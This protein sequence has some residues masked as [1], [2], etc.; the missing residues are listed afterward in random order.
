MSDLL[1]ISILDIFKSYIFRLLSYLGQEAHVK[2]HKHFFFSLTS[3]SKQ[4][5][6]LCWEQSGLSDVDITVLHTY[7]L[8]S[9]TENY[10]MLPLSELPTRF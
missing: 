2:N 10:R 7:T 1:Y 4:E 6:F 8:W 3:V 9:N 5:I